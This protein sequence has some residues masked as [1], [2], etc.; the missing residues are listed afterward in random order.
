MITDLGD[1][2]EKRAEAEAEVCEDQKAEQDGAANQQNGL[3][4]LDPRGRQHA[5]EDD[6]ND[7]QDAH[8]TDRNGE[9]DA[10]AFSSSAT[11]APA[12]TICA[13]M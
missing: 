8:A 4:D 9:A 2:R 12:P 6:V 5:A 11:S 13:I 1:S 7:H 10:G 3:D